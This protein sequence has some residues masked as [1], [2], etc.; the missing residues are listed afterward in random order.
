MFHRLKM[1]STL[2]FDSELSA[3]LRQNEKI[4]VSTVK[5]MFQWK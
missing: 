4:S 3:F 5:A 1:E 2:I